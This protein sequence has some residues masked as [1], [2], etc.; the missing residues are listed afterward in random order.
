LIKS[1]KSGASVQKRLERASE[2]QSQYEYL[3]SMSSYFKGDKLYLIYNEGGSS[4]TL[5][6]H[7]Y[8]A[9]L[10]EVSQKEMKTYAEH[11]I[12]LNVRKD[13]KMGDNKFMMW[14]NE[15]KNVGSVVIKFDE[16]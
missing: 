6:T 10:D 15:G 11:K 4:Y 12:Y 13:Y 2:G 3:L 1:D 9:N 16:K 7:V 5:K 14:G 8:S